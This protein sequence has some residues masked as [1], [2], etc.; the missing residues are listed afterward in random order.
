MFKYESAYDEVLN[1]LEESNKIT[2]KANNKHFETLE[3]LS[4]IA[5]GLDLLGFEKEAEITTKLVEGL[6]KKANVEQG[7]E[8]NTDD[9]EVMLEGSDEYKREALED[10]YLELLGDEIDYDKLLDE[11]SEPE[12][13]EISVDDSEL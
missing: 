5:G 2:K 11:L 12:Y 1:A 7:W 4:E 3:V 9:K 6:S 8:F 13:E 10:E